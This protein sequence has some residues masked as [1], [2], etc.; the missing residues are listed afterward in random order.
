MY[1]ALYTP[2]SFNQKDLVLF[3]KDR[4]LFKKDKFV[5]KKE[6]GLFKK[7]TYVVHQLL[8]AK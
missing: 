4:H 6:Q 5:L 3:K 1:G 7:R 8:Q 2:L